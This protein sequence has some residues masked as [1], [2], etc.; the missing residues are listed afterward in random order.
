M[1][2]TLGQWD[3]R[4]KKS[5]PAI[6]EWIYGGRSSGRTLSTLN[7]HKSHH[8]KPQNGKHPDE[9]RIPD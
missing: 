2:G 4:E 5:V 6:S 7:S 8:R 1:A 3:Q 9:M